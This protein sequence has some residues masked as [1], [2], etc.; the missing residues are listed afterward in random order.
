M[1]YQVPISEKYGLTLEE[2]AIYFGIGINKLREI[3]KEDE[4]SSF[5]LY[6]G[7]KMLI[8]RTKMEKYLDECYSI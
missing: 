1:Q 8:K 7:R 6:V 3:I 2:A 5:I 4:S